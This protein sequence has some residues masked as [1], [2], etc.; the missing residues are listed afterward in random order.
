MD[1]GYPRGYIGGAFPW[2]PSFTLGVEEA[3]RSIDP[4]ILGGN[5][6]SPPPKKK[7]EESKKECEY[8]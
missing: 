7:E 8:L 6:V 2:N 1:H 5:P 3:V 4:V